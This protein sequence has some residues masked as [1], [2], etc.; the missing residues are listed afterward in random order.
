MLLQRM[1][2]KVTNACIVP[3][4]SACISLYR[5]RTTRILIKASREGERGGGEKDKERNVL[6]RDQEKIFG[7]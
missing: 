7:K 2:S 4:V 3:R 6:D 5:K 1:T